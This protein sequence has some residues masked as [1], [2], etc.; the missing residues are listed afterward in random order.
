M[1]K[2]AEA[3]THGGQGSRSSTGHNDISFSLDDEGIE[4]AGATLK[5]SLQ[6]S[7]A[8]HARPCS[9]VLMFPSQGGRK[10][11]SYKCMRP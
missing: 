6:G 11:L 7:V 4:Q 8:P 1:R 9:D 3:S 10:S 2:A 5:D